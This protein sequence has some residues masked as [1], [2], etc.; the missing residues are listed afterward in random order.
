MWTRAPGAS[1]RVS[2]GDSVIEPSHRLVPR[3]GKRRDRGLVV[4]G[5]PTRKPE[6]QRLATLDDPGERFACAGTC[7]PEQPVD[8]R[9]R[10]LEGGAGHAYRREGVGVVVG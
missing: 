5:P 3:G 8:V 7:I 2:S 4:K 9:A 1:D 6:G 10:R